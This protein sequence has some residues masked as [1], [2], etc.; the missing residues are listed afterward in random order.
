MVVEICKPFYDI[1]EKPFSGNKEVSSAH[2]LTNDQLFH[3][4]QWY[5]YLWLCIS[6]SVFPMR[7][8]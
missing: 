5:K 3:F 2:T 8:L 7:I 6:M 1:T 4:K